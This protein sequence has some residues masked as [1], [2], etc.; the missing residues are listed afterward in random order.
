M[1]AILVV[2]LLLY[3]RPGG[4]APLGEMVARK[5]LQRL[6]DDVRPELVMEA[7]SH[8]LTP[9]GVEPVR[10]LLPNTSVHE[11]TCFLS[12]GILLQNIDILLSLDMIEKEAKNQANVMAEHVETLLG[13]MNG[14]GPLV[15]KV[16]LFRKRMMSNLY[17]PGELRGFFAEIQE[18]VRQRS[19]TGEMKG[20]RKREALEFG[21]WMSL[22]NRDL[23]LQAQRLNRG[24]ELRHLLLPGYVAAFRAYGVEHLPREMNAEIR[25]ACIAI[26]AAADQ[27]KSGELTPKQATTVHEAVKGII[28]HA[29]RRSLPG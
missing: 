18:D 14:Q 23:S 27:L 7:V 1:A 13:S 26:S 17:G 15:Q 5:S 10:T 19:N 21:L 20:Q 24:N 12:L 16:S 6:P 8:I 25:P 9:E 11:A 3:L 22:L 4:P 2:S 28:R 29:L